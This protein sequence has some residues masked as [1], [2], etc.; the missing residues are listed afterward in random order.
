MPDRL[1]PGLPHPPQPPLQP[2]PRLGAAGALPRPG[3]SSL[4][5]RGLG[6]G[7]ASRTSAFL[8]VLEKVTVPCAS[9]GATVLLLEGF[10]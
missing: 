8:F 6:T 1:P 10:L 3:T 5:A 2:D 4:L 9:P 7:L